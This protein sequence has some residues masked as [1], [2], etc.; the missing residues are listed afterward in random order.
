AALYG[1]LPYSPVPVT[2]S[3]PS[4]CLSPVG[5]H[6]MSGLDAGVL[7]HRMEEHGRS[8]GADVQRWAVLKRSFVRGIGRIDRPDHKGLHGQGG[9]RET[10]AS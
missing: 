1:P 2:S 8:S 5:T 10:I 9:D 7:E 6:T 4:N 3:N